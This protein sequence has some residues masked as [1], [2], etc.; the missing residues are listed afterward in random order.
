MLCVWGDNS[1]G[2]FYTVYLCLIWS[3]K[4]LSYLEQR[5][6]R[7]WT[8]HLFWL[9]W[10]VKGSKRKLNYVKAICFHCKESQAREEK[11]PWGFLWRIYL[12][13]ATKGF[14][15]LTDEK[16]NNLWFLKIWGLLPVTPLMPLHQRSCIIHVSI[17][18]KCSR[19]V[20]VR[21]ISLPSFPS[22][23]LTSPFSMEH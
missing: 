13:I 10:F 16:V 9:L 19:Y 12:A 15:E 3:H 11:N 18:F 6:L 7:F 1:D 14:L 20:V 8:S 5:P 21:T 4:E 22:W 17:W 23:K 2:L